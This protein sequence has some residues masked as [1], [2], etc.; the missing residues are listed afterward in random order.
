MH[1]SYKLIHEGCSDFRMCHQLL[2]GGV[3]ETLWCND[4]TLHVH[5][6][7][8]RHFSQKNTQTL[9]DLKKTTVSS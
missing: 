9:N 1:V 7:T 6:K 8:E 3:P 4:I 2:T 5:A